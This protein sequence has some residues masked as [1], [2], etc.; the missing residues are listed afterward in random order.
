MANIMSPFIPR[1]LQEAMAALRSPWI[2][3][4]MMAVIAS[5]YQRGSASAIDKQKT[6]NDEYDSAERS[7]DHY[8]NT[9]NQTRRSDFY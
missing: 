4:E 7:L 1:I 9:N 3:C 2:H 6:L 5:L 8:K